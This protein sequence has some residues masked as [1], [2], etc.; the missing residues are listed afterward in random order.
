MITPEEPNNDNVHKII[1]KI[2][3][4]FFQKIHL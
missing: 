2:M 3:K 1:A 4:K